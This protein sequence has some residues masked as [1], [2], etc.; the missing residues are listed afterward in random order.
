L[1]RRKQGD[2]REEERQNRTGSPHKN[3]RIAG[4]KIA[5]PRACPW[6]E[7]AG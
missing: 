3:L 5:R 7:H 2:E 1:R 4:G 6:T